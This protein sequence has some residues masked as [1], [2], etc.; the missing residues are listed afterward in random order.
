MQSLLYGVPKP[1]EPFVPQPGFVEM[2]NRAFEII[3]IEP[4]TPLPLRDETHLVFEGEAPGIL[5]MHAIYDEAKSLDAGSIVDK[6][7]RLHDV[8]VNERDLFARL[9][10]TPRFIRARRRHAEGDATAGAA[11]IE[12]ENEARLLRRAA[13]DMAVDAEG[14]VIAA[15]PRGPALLMLEAGPPHEGAI[16]KNPQILHAVSLVAW[17]L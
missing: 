6:L 3:G 14:T 4:R 7:H 11:R 2:A 8:A 16:S 5:T 15:Q 17:R 1:G 9:E 10:V 12:P 13:M